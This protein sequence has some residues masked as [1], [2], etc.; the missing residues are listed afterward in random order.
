[1]LFF[2]FLYSVSVLA[3]EPR[4]RWKFMSKN[5][6]FNLSSNFKELAKQESFEYSKLKWIL[7][8]NVTKRKLY[9]IKNNIE[10]KT[11]YI[12][13]NGKQV[14][15]VNDWP[16]EIPNDST[17]LIAIYY[18]GKLVKQYFLKDLFKCGYNITFSAS[19][20]SWIF[21]KMTINFRK[22]T[23]KFQTQELVYFK[24]NLSDG[25]LIS[26]K[27]NELI[28]DNS[29]LVYGKI[30]K[31]GGDNYSMEVCHIVYGAVPSDG[32]IKFK[33]SKD[34]LNN[35]HQTV[36]ITN[37]ISTEYSDLNDII[38]NSCLYENQKLN[39]KTT[40]L[41]GKITCN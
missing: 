12:S 37:G 36:L 15:I 26:V 38:F 35:F 6:L 4:N 23:L 28:K 24:I 41:F 32:I 25:K 20:F 9:E 2:F 8:N 40:Y 27:K 31:N 34:F 22:K 19:H 29:L 14:I 18:R 33:S 17:E 39:I 11:A 13:N 5:R 7:I 16:P 3:D 10:Y 21:D 1:M 30:I